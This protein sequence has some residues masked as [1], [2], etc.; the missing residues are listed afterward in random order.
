MILL[1]PSALVVPGKLNLEKEGKEK[2]RKG[3]M[4]PAAV[5]DALGAAVLGSADAGSSAEPILCSQ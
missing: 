2:E 4:F 1:E 3:E 5:S